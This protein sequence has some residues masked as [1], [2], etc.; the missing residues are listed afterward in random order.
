MLK[1]Y[2]YRLLSILIVFYAGLSASLAHE[3]SNQQT[4]ISAW[5]SPIDSAGPAIPPSTIRQWLR[6]S[7]GGNKIRV[8]FSNRFGE[9]PLSL[10]SV[11]IAKSPAK[12]KVDLRDSK[13]LSFGGLPT[14]IIYPGEEIVSDPVDM[15]V[16]ALQTLAIS[17]FTPTGATQT[18]L[19]GASMQN[20]FLFNDKN[21]AHEETWE[22]ETR[23]D[24]RYFISGLEVLS[25]ST[26]KVIVIIG[27]SITDG[28]GIE[29]DN[30]HRW[31]DFL[32]ERIQ[33]RPELS[34]LAVVNAGIAGN[35]VMRDAATPF[36]GTAAISR[37]DTDVLQQRAI[38]SIIFLQGTND[39]LANTLLQAAE[40]Q[41][42]LNELI[43]GIESL[44]AKSHAHGYK[45]YGGTLTP[46]A[47]STGILTHTED[48]EKM[49]QQLNTWIRT[50]GK[51]DAVID[52][53]AVLRDPQQTHRLNPRFDSG[54]HTHPN[55][56]G[57]KAMAMAI[58]LKLFDAKF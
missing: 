40:Q 34:H 49:R 2:F 58:D 42:S 48:A 21:I 20:A 23:D 53:D 44:I 22:T 28:V 13:T 30:Y 14:V 56:A 41:V 10:T 52:F 46:R 50:S 9:T 27:D 55:A 5:Y 47:G 38:Q 57:Y 18:S 36:V 39:I 1:L 8:R 43:A 24:S 4:W 19:H 3:N 54:D 11:S 33:Q 12:F 17:F 45:I 32:S 51:F 16:K 15:E 35:R 31:P 26:S 6:T 29:N 37:F 25:A 7:I